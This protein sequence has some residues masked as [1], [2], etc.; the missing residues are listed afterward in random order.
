M[1]TNDMPPLR[2]YAESGRPTTKLSSSTA[3][4][5][6]CPPARTVFSW[7]LLVAAPAIAHS[8]QIPA[9]VKQNIEARIATGNSVGIVVGI[10]NVAGQGFFSHGTRALR[11]SQPVDENT[12]Y[13]IGSI[14]K[15]FTGILLADMVIRGEL[16]LTTPVKDLLPQRVSVPERDG[17]Q[18]TLLDL[19]T[20]TSGLPRL[21][22]NMSPADRANPYADYTVRQLYA[23][24]ARHT[25][26]R[27]I[28]SEYEY[29]KPGGWVAR[30]R[31]RA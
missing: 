5:P 25:L 24:L 22:N 11:R 14:T 27:D 21:P 31:S 28:G 19:S 16:T 1:G 23:F 10:V 13:E 30:P 4:L 29:S 9:A 3:R 2:R 7:L 26:R 17:R 6:A 12:L 18:I 20:H 8:Q 15:V